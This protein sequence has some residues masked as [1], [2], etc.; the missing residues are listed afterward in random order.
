M[1]WYR[2]MNEAKALEREFTEPQP[3]FEEGRILA[4]GT[5]LDKKSDDEKVPEENA[6]G[7]KTE[8]ESKEEQKEEQILINS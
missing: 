7:V 1:V 6:D 3:T 5:S 2:K 8:E 4:D